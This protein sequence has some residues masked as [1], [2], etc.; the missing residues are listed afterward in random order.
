MF[1]A[2]GGIFFHQ[3]GA[4][5]PNWMM[6]AMTASGFVCMAAGNFFTHLFAGEQLAEI[7]A[8]KNPVGANYIPNQFQSRDPL[9]LPFLSG[10]TISG[11]VNMTPSIS[12]SAPA[13]TIQPK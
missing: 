2:G 7:T 9:P 5:V 1:L 6:V 4:T 8:L 3:A 12:S 13:E 10:M 11:P